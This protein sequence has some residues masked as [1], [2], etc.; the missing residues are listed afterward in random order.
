MPDYSAKLKCTLVVGRQGKGK[1]SFCFRYLANAVTHQALNPDPAR[2]V[3]IY[4][5]K[6]EAANRFGVPAVTTEHGIESALASRFVIFNPHPM[7]PGDQEARIFGDKQLNDYK[8]GLR[9]F[10]QLVFSICQ[11]PGAEGRKIIYLDETREFSSRHWVPPELARVFRLGRTEG[12]ELLTSTQFPSDFHPD[13]K[14]SVTEWVC[15]QITER[16]HVDALRDYLPDAD[17]VTS[18][19]DGEF[20]SRSATDGGELRGRLF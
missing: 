10:C 13:L 11:R 4:D 8:V 17:R 15:F 2:C 1:T 19:A 6:G 5:W 7:F 18:L 20:I 16:L 12:I 9:W 14:G 3:F